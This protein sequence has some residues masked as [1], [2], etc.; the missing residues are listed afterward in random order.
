MKPGDLVLYSSDV[1][2]MRTILRFT[3]VGVI[4]AENRVLEMHGAA[5]R[6]T[7]DLEN[8]FDGGRPTGPKV[9]DLRARI[10]AYPGRIWIAPLLRRRGTDVIDPSAYRDLEYYEAYV[11]HYLRSCVANRWFGSANR[12]F[13]S[14]NRWFGPANRWCR[15]KPPTSV[16][17]TEFVG[18]VL[19]D[20]GV[21]VGDAGC[22]TPSALASLP[23]VFERPERVFC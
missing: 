21:D 16:F 19:R 17:C 2:I 7:E 11:A 9:Y 10:A 4:V 13:G 18:M 23:G 8:Y 20:M 1:S 15:R 22:L 12:W 3:H 6:G 14:A 5:D